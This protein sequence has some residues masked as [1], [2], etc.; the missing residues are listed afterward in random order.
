MTYWRCSWLGSH[1]ARSK[2]PWAGMDTRK[3]NPYKTRF[4]GVPRERFRAPVLEGCRQRGKVVCCVVAWFQEKLRSLSNLFVEVCR[5]CK[6]IKLRG[7]VVSGVA[8]LIISTKVL[9][10]L[11]VLSRVIGLCFIVVGRKVDSNLAASLQWKCWVP[12]RIWCCMGWFFPCPSLLRG[13]L[14]VRRGY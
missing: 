4:A 2:S 8:A 7:K 13:I 10:Y 6:S 12:L 1:F 5:F 9:W 3:I 14:N 11:F